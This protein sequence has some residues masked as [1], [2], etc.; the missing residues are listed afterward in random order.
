LRVCHAAHAPRSDKPGETSAPPSG[1]LRPFSL[2]PSA[3][4]PEISRVETRLMHPPGTRS[5]QLFRGG[6]SADCRGVSRRSC[7]RQGCLPPGQAGS[8]VLLGKLA[9][10]IS[11]VEEA[12]S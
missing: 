1:S 11:K 2:R 4:D 7:T 3:A 12:H 8:V 9:P 10:I 6:I 5:A